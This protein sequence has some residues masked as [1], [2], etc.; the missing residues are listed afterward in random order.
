MIP[1]LMPIYNRADLAFVRGEGAYVFDDQGHRYLDFVAGIAV[2]AFGHA[3][4]HLVAA[5]KDQAE[6]IWHSSNLYRI[7]GQERLAARLVDASF[8]DTVFFTNSGAEAIECAVKLVR[9]FQHGEGR[10]QRYRLI[11]FRQAFH[12]RTMTAIAATNQEKLRAGFGPLPDWFDVVPFGDVEAAEAALGPETA[13]ILIEPVQGEGGVSAA[14]QGFLKALRALADQNDLLLVFDEIQCGMGRTGKLFAHEH[15]GVTPD[16]LA[17][18]KGIG[19]GFPLGACLATQRAAQHMTAGSHGSTYGGNPLAMAVGNAALD[20]LLAP[21]FLD[22]VAVMGER[23]GTALDRLVAARPDMFEAVR[24]RGLMRGLKLKKP[25]G[26]MVAACRQHFLL[27]A[28]AAGDV[29]RLLPPLIIDESHIVEA[30]EKIAAAG[31]DLAP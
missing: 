24:G 3:H 6:K 21:G 8:A 12:G 17:A 2:T 26:D 16:V 19:G 9:R 23:L 18:A 13:G 31:D 1:S 10:P 20:L 25:V 14:P 27:T 29:L 28:P 5:L 22:R 30:A 15:D 4:P 7:P 11:T